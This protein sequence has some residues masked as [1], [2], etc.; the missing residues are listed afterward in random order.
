MSFHAIYTPQPLF[1]AERCQAF[2]NEHGYSLVSAVGQDSSMR[3]YFRVHHNDR[4][5]ILMETV[6]DSSPHCMQGHKLSDFM[7]IGAW[8]RGVGLRAPQIYAVDEGAGYMLLEDFGDTSFAVYL[9]EGGEPAQIYSAAV[10]VLEHLKSQDCPLQLPHYFESHVHAGH[11]K[12]I[13]YYAPTKLKNMGDV[14]AGYHAAW[15]EIEA[16]A[17]LCE[18]GFV[19]VDFHAENLMW[20]ADDSAGSR[21]GVL[22]FQGA[23]NGPLAYDLANLLED[24]R[25]DIGDELR[26]EILSRQSAETRHWY[27]ILATQFHCRVIGQFIKMANEDGKHGY[28][29]YIPR[30]ERYLANAL[31]DP[32]LAPLAMFFK[33][34]NLDFTP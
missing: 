13:E 22:D 19:H 14:L 1:N 25:I 9:N 11:Q 29:K 18:M 24:A 33:Q 4:A 7:E 32:I 28:L 8:L 17:P 15:A 2:L 12:I 10:D 31:K 23:M 30:L 5:A 20:L 34:I 27:R 6:P 21:I 3:R 26:G 16:A